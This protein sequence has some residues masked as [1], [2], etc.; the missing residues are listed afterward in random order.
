MAATAAFLRY[1][2]KKT[3]MDD[4]ARAAGVSRQGLYLYFDTKDFLFREAL[5]YLVS[6]MISAAHSVAED[7]NLSLRDRLL[8]VFEALHG[9]AFQ[10][11]SR[12]HAFELL[13][14]AQSAAGALLV[15]LDRDLM[16]IAAALLAEA[17]AADRWEEAGV[18]VALEAEIVALRHQLNVLRRKSPKRPAFSNFDRLIFACLYRISPRIVNALVIVKPETVIRWHGAGFRFFWRW[19]SRSRGGRPKVPLEIR[20]LIREMSLANPLWGAPRIHGELLKLGIDVGQTS[21]AKYMARQRKPPSQGW[22]TFLR[23]H[24]DGLASM[25]LFVVPTLSFRLLYGLL[26]L[27]HGRRRILWLGVTAHPER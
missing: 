27:S 9:S 11:A 13:Q 24:A 20:Q 8:G 2:F 14:S 10:S 15:Q 26:I 6:H 17:G 16:G 1:G 7:R 18:T 5:Q 19:K 23:N 21:V 22:M 4:V 3:S 25:D 12:E